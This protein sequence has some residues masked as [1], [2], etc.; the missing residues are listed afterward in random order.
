M[1]TRISFS[2]L[3]RVGRGASFALVMLAGAALPL[4]T[5]QA[6]Q[7]R[8]GSQDT[9]VQRRQSPARLT[10][11]V[12]TA[13]RTAKNVFYVPKPVSVLD[14]GD[15]SRK[16][17]NTAVDLFRELPG[18]DVTG[19]GVNQVRPN[20]RGQR[21]QR[22]L[23]LED[24]MRLNNS[25]RQQDF[26]ELPALVDVHSVD[27]VEVVRGPASV[28][29][30][31]DAIGGVVNLITRRPR[32]E[33]AH[34]SLGY[35][36]STFDGQHKGLA[37]LSGRFGDLAFMASGT[38][39]DADD[40]SAPAGSYGDI[41]LS[42]RTRVFNSGTQDYSV[43]AYASYAFA[44]R[45]EVFGKYERYRAD[46]AGFGF[47]DP[48]D[49]A[50][51]SPFIEIL[52]PFQ[53]FD[54]YTVGYRG[55][56]LGTVFAD[57]V[58]LVGYYQDNDRRLDNNIVI[59]F[60]PPGAEL[61]VATENF[62][63]I[64]TFGAR[65]EATKLAGSR[66]LLTYGAD[67][68]RDDSENT[69]AALTTVLGFGPPMTSADSTPR[70]P[71]ASYR[72]VGVFAQGDIQISDRAS[73]I[74][75]GRFQDVRAA[76]Q[77]TPGLSD[78]LVDDSDQT[79]VGAINA[80]FSVTDNLTLVGAV[81]RAFRSPNLVERFFNGPAPEG[82]GFQVPNPALGPETSLNFDVGIRYRDR[83]LYL[84]GF[85]FRNEIRNGIRIAATGDSLMGLPTFWNVNVDKLRFVGVELNGDVSLPV[86]ISVAA[87][88][89]HLD[90]K[91]VN[92]PE[93]PV[94]DTFD[95][96][97]N[98]QLRY[99]HP[100]NRFWAAYEF[101][102]NGERKDVFATTTPAVGPVLPSFATHAVRAGVTVF[103]RGTHTQRLGVAV[104]NLT[105]EL[106][107]EFA[108]AAFFRPQPRRGVVVTW[109]VTF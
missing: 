94:G 71:N 76:T 51:G 14:R 11:V 2:R 39:R 38:F 66:V 63:D 70:V 49:F 91:D 32:Y 23:L 88:Y 28:L 65:L 19:V 92:D 52:Y 44:E 20:I 86:G 81:G 106:Y 29:Y 58:S 45:H 105:N 78:P 108:N 35:R 10:P 30:G 107:A 109:D 34:G 84:E 100:S 85:V 87:N 18:L 43:D 74:V 60:G 41:T 25:R 64:S 89:T 12:V 4:S 67:F 79:L 24:G 50:P 46:T 75:G 47:V 103:R 7:Q 21:G 3:S 22:I 37:S 6:A 90:T 97:L 27:R 61:Q 53:D 69:D 98:A 55:D 48:D 77:R 80:L 96:K 57:K 36:Y 73:V 59:P 82:G 5:L 40:Y 93:N 56:R 62:T 83:L 15:I 42:D 1:N 104:T 72:S 13:T 101:R 16:M 95:D 54:K 8:E 9:T 99:S 102:W 68:F 31:T 17:P 26:G 33:G